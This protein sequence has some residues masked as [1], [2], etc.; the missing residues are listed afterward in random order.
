MKFSE[1]LRKAGHSI[2]EANF[3]NPFV[4]G[5]G[6]GTLPVDKF[7]FFLEQDYAF[8]MEYCRFFGLILAKAGNLEEM[9]KFSQILQATL[10]LEMDL[11]R[12]VCSDFG[13]TAKRLEETK[14]APFNLGYTSYLLKTVYQRD[15][16][17]AMATLLPCL[18]GYNE[19]GLRLKEQGLPQAKHYKEWILTY[20]SSDFTELTDWCKGWID[21]CAIGQSADRL[22]R[23][24]EIFLT[25]SGWEYLFWEMAWHKLEWPG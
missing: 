13:I 8:L 21:N 1:Q 22:K 6:Q 14:A 10:T 24:E 11:H 9:K 12:R 7:V 18:W 4:Q 23:L 5:I 2:W 20:S 25:T 17:D 16:A 19:I 15:T 3:N